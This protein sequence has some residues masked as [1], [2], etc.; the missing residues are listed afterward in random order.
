MQI[1]RYADDTILMAESEELKSLLMKVKEESERWGHKES[2][3]TEW[4]NWTESP[5]MCA[6]LVTPWQRIHLQCRQHK[7]DAWVGKILQKRAWQ[8]SPIFL[9]EEAHGP[10]SVADYG[11]WGCKG[12]NTTKVTDHGTALVYTSKEEKALVVISE[13]LVLS[14]PQGSFR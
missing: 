10:S 11:Q 14:S 6:S 12:L 5:Y 9:P 2:D 7:F 4:L 1:L 13:R 3:T 8:L